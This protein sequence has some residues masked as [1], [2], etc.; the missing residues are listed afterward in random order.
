MK[1]NSLTTAVVAGIAGVAGF[2]GL[3]NAVDLN[4]DGLGQVLIYPYY[5]VNKS[6]DT[7]FS[8]V[9]TTGIGKAVKVRFLEG[10]NSREV[11]DFNLFLSPHDVWT[12]RVSQTD[13]IENGGG[14]AVF[15]S[16]KSCTS[17]T[18]PA[19][20]QPFSTAG[21]DGSGADPDSGSP[22]PYDGGPTDLTRT[23]EGYLELITM[24]DI[25]A[26]TPLAAD[27]T[28]QQNGQPDGGVP[29]DCS[30][31]SLD[32]DAPIS[33]VAPT[34]GG[35][36]GSGTIVN[37]GEGTFFGYTADAIDGFTELA[38]YHGTESLQP[39]LQDANNPS[40][41]TAPGAIA[42]AF[43]F[44]NG[45]LLTADYDFGVDAVSAVLMSD[46]LYN[47]YFVDQTNF[48]ANTDW[49][50]TFPTK[51]FYVDDTLY[52]R[53]PAAPFVE[54]FD[55]ESNVT[56]GITL[57][58]REEGHTTRTGGFSPPVGTRPSSLPYEV[59]VI[60]FLP[61]TTAGAPSGVLGSYLRPNIT[62]YGID[63][64]LQLDLASGD[65]GHALPGGVSPDIGDVTLNGLPATGYMGYNIINTNAQPGQ[66]A[67]YGGLFRHRANR[68]CSGEG[69]PCS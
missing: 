31:G 2:A 26:G 66:L 63:G 29:P 24:G 68:S 6:Q 33:V 1:R 22:I 59:N 60:S 53:A 15:T 56:V 18:I 4:P 17:P 40:L 49:I 14:G 37:V 42:R 39:S 62:P 25:P 69:G 38:L 8:V 43:V 23:R 32:N 10:Y 11:L 5:T 65:G 20:G 3:A 50:V 47:E 13:D 35:L 45:Q 28:H 16:D 34:S 41:V 30:Q 7:L 61:T 46:T 54:A 57:Y 51:R 9:N 58:D 12:A 52:S 48:G 21:F 36:F 19:E 27:I 55:G 64:W 44:I 67:N